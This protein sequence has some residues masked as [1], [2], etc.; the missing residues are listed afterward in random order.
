MSCVNR[1]LLPLTRFEWHYQH[2][3]LWWR[4]Y[5]IAANVV[6]VVMANGIDAT[7]TN[8]LL[9]LLLAATPRYGDGATLLSIATATLVKC[10]RCFIVGHWLSN[11]LPLF[12]II[13]ITIEYGVGIRQRDMSHDDISL[14]LVGEERNIRI[15]YLVL[16]YANTYIASY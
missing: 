4:R 8:M 10:R 7:L 6:V 3:T 5:G 14:T 12:T 2:T 1:S 16:V 9:K 11:T 13:A 15:L